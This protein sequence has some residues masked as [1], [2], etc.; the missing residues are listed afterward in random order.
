MN[1]AKHLLLS[2]C[3]GRGVKTG[4]VTGKP[5]FRWNE[6][7]TG[8]SAST[9]LIGQLARLLTNQITLNAVCVSLRRNLSYF[10]YTTAPV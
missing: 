5:T 6:G 1:H 9:A 4:D 2:I 3:Q 10:T 7:T 8:M